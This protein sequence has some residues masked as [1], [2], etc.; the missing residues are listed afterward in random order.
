MRRRILDRGYCDCFILESDHLAGRQSL[1]LEIRRHKTSGFLTTQQGR[2][3]RIGDVG[4]IWFRRYTSAQAYGSASA[5]P[6]ANDLVNNECR[7]TLTALLDAEFRGKWISTPVSTINASNKI[8]QAIAASKCGFRVPET[9]ITQSKLEVLE[10]YSRHSAKIIVKAISGISRTLIA[11]RL[12]E[13]PI[14]IKEES[15]LACPTLYQEFIPGS[16]HIRLHCFGNS[17]HAVLI[18]SPHVDSR[19]DLSVPIEPWPVPAAVHHLTRRVLDELDLEMGVVDLKQTPDGELVWLEVN[20]Q[21][22]FLFLEPL[23]NL[24]IGDI[25]VEYLL[26]TVRTL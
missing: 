23:S 2:R 19:F 21:G 7:D 13:N 20:P 18:H 15:Y 3:I 17:S 5:D 1:S 10:F 4:L 24:K 26:G 9:L 12:L 22:Q 11:T 8:S 6:V 14:A 25:F 16:R